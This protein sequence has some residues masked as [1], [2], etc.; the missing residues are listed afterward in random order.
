MSMKYMQLRYNTITFMCHYMEEILE[1]F[2]QKTF[3]SFPLKK[4][5]HGHLGC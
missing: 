5:R 2:P 4:E 3:I 1:R